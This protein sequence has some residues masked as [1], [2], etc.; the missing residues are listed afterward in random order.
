M[1]RTTITL[2]EDV[3]KEARKRAIDERIAFA[4]IVNKALRRYLTARE[5]KHARKM[6]GIEFLNKLAKY[7]LKSGPKDLAKNHDKYTWE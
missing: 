2:D 5:T 4:K 1:M 6:T 7:G 3:F